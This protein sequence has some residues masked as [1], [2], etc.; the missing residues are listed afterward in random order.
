M[1]DVKLIINDEEYE[2]SVA[3]YETLVDVLRDRLDMREVKKGCG[4]GGCGTCTVLVDGTPIY[5]CLMLAVQAQGKDIT[6]IKGLAKYGEEL[7][8]L[9]KK[10][11]ELGAIQC[12]YCT[13]GVIL[14]AKALLDKNPHPSEE[15]VKI[16][17]SGNVCRC[18]GYLQ[19]V[20]AI[21]AT[22]TEG[23]Q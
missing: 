21:Q 7:H 13:P 8:P 23:R 11:M 1:K 5:S 6:T 19:I 17:I 14:T 22:A 4:E 15:E 2:V 16:A 12:G 10:F 18:T 20:E 9:Q 3:P